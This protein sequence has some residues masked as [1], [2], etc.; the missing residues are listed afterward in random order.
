MDIIKKYK[1]YK[2]KPKKETIDDFC[3]VSKFKLQPQQLFIGD[4]FSSSDSPN[5]M[6][7]YHQIGAGKT[8]AAITVAEKMKKKLNIMVVLPAALIGNFTDE[9]RTPCPGENEYITE[10]EKKQLSKLEIASTEYNNIISKTEERIKKYYTIYSYHKF[11]ELAKHNK[12]TKSKSNIYGFVIT[13]HEFVYK[14]PFG[15]IT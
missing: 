5:G 1:K 4:Y 6:L 14:L 9:L 3:S 8:C 13:S 15:S 7:L 10:N 12:I 11:I 2:I